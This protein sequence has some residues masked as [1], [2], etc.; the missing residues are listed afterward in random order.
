MSHLFHS[1][2]LLHSILHFLKYPLL[3]FIVHFLYC[4][5]DVLHFGPHIRVYFESPPTHD[6]KIILQ[7]GNFILQRK[8][9]LLWE[10]ILQWEII[11]LWTNHF[12]MKYHFTIGKSFCN[13]QVLQ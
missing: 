4:I 2:C 6:G 1:L 9:I 7:Y 12:A 11:L 10:I 13:G 5:F 3:A 8:I